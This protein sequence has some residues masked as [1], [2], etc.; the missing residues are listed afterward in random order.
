M[1]IWHCVDVEDLVKI[2]LLVC[3]KT[4]VDLNKDNPVSNAAVVN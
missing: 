4:H 1:R 2:R 3:N